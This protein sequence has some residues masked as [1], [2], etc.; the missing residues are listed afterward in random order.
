MSSTQ[1]EYG[2]LNLGAASVY[3]WQIG[4]A[5]S[6]GGVAGNESFY[7]YNFSN[8]TVP[9]EIDTSNN[10]IIFG[11]NNGYDGTLQVGA[12]AY[13][14]HRDTGQTTTSIL[15]TYNNDNTTLNFRLKGVSDA[16]A[17]MTIKGSGKVGIGTTSPAYK[18]VVS[19]GGASGIEFS[20]NAIAGLNEILSY[21]RSTSVYE[22]LRLTVYGF[23]IYTNNGGNSLAITNTGDVGIGTSNPTDKLTVSGDVK[24][25]TGADKVAFELY[26]GVGTQTNDVAY[27]HCA[28]ASSTGYNLLRCEGD[29]DDPTAFDAFTVRGDGTVTASGDVVA[30]SD[31]KLKKNI[32]TLDGSKVYKMRGVSF[33]RID[34][35]KK[36]SGV[37]AQEIQKI[38]PELI[39]ES[40]ETLGVAYG[41]LTGYLIEAIKELEARVKE[42]ENK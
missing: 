23:D 35:G 38:A 4:K 20:P 36:S 42:L 11:Q 8:S 27:I 29:S 24:F 33:D 19:N 34:T 7:I 15:S 16:D 9:V 37:I 12:R 40:N 18:L 30:Y 22:N 26:A 25:Q 39:S 21:N 10:F 13:F 2:Y 41:N 6:S 14:Q 31:K 17:Q 28:T 3:G 32:K 5:P 1:A